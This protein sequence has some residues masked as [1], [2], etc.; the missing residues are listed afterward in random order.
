MKICNFFE[1]SG[2]SVFGFSRIRRRPKDVVPGPES[3]R[4][5]RIC[6]AVRG[7]S[8]WYEQYE[9]SFTHTKSNRHSSLAFSYDIFDFSIFQRR[10]SFVSAVSVTHLPWVLVEP[11][12]PGTRFVDSSFFY[13]Q[14]QKHK[15]IRRIILNICFG[16]RF[17]INSRT[18]VY[19]LRTV[20]RSSVHSDCSTRVKSAIIVRNVFVHVVAFT[21]VSFK[22]VFYFQVTRSAFWWPRRTATRRPASWKRPSC[23]RKTYRRSSGPKRRVCTKP[24]WPPPS[25]FR[26]FPT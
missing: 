2:A 5:G 15:R 6:P 21:F 7:R 25:T 22:A 17:S 13:A 9:T 4:P 16:K 19:R 24:A 8:S 11:R 18:N 1:I 26:W 14:F 3:G 20:V 23:G 12:C 10:N